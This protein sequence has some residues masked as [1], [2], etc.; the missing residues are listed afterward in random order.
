MMPFILTRILH[1]GLSAA[2]FS[3]FDILESVQL[4]NWV[5]SFQIKFRFPALLKT[6]DQET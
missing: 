1:D 6:H 5:S 3:S 4:I 2:L